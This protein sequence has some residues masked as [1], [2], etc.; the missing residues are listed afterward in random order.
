MRKLKDI[1]IYDEVVFIDPDKPEKDP[2]EHEFPLNFVARAVLGQ[3]TVLT[4]NH[5]NSTDET[6]DRD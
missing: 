3:V 5:V 4:K 2:S 6:A 1:K